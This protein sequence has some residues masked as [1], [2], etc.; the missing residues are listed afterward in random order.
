MSSRSRT[1]TILNQR[2]WGVSGRY[3][4]VSTTLQ[5]GEDKTGHISAKSNEGLLFFNNVFPIQIRKILGLP[6]PRLL[7]KIISSSTTRTDP[8][9]ILEKAKAK[10]SLPINATEVLPRI[11]EGGAFVKFTLDDGGAGKPEVEIEKLLQQYLNDNPVKPWW[12]PLRRVEASVVKGRPWVEDLMR[13]PT[14]R[15]RA[16]FVPAEPGAGVSEAVELSQEQLFELFRPYG[17]LSDIVVQ[18]PDSK[19]LPKFAYL[20]FAGLGDATMAKNWYV[21]FTIVTTRCLLTFA[22]CMATY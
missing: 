20:D 2:P 6:I 7:H 18:P 9:R 12:S 5:A 16:E 1:A 3:A 22:V 19:V 11:R 10:S 14:S 13:P 21:L 4:T 17:K 15:L 8:N